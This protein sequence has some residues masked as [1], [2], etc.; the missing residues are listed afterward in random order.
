MRKE[1]NSAQSYTLPITRLIQ[2]MVDAPDENHGFMMRLQLEAA[3]RSLV[4]A[5]SDNPNPGERPELE[6]T[7]QLPDHIEWY[8][9]DG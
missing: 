5:S 1:P 4:F 2:Q 6:V 9:R 7:Y 8:V 3:Y